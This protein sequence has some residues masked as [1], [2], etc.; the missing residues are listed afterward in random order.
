MQG[1]KHRYTGLQAHKYTYRCCR[2]NSFGFGF[3]YR[4]LYRYTG[5]QVYSDIGHTY[6]CTGTQAHQYTDTQANRCT[7]MYTGTDGTPMYG[8]TGTQA[9]RYT[10]THAHR[11]TGT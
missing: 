2:E 1:H 7:D 11:H 3:V 9:H 4:G 6:I 10:G 8:H 5:T